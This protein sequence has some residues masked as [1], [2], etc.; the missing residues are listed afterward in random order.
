MPKTDFLLL[1]V[2]FKDV[3]GMQTSNEQNWTCWQQS[4][5]CPCCWHRVLLVDNK[6]H[7]YFLKI[8]LSGSSRVVWIV[9]KS[10]PAIWGRGSTPELVEYTW[11]SDETEREGWSQWKEKDCLQGDWCWGKGQRG[12]WAP[13][14]EGGWCWMMHHSTLVYESW[15]NRGYACQIVSLGY[16]L[17]HL[18]C[19][20]SCHITHE[21]GYCW[22][23]VHPSWVG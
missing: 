22:L 8:F 11:S 19:I 3:S 4:Y 14:W 21:L 20:S 18:L 16:K 13:V 2:W 12:H 7:T 17:A 9:V 15:R 6:S 23:D 10:V 5:P 1:E